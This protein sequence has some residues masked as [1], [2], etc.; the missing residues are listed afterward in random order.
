MEEQ[1]EIAIMMGAGDDD[2]EL[3]MLH[4]IIGVV[5]DEPNNEGIPFDINNLSDEEV[6]LNFRFSRNDIL[7]LRNALRVPEEILTEN[8]NRTDG[9]C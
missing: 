9:N 4:N 3:L 7:R 5:N 8:G 1:L 2:I 6:K